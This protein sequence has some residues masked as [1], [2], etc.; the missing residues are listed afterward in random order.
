VCLQV[1]NGD[2]V[3]NF[4]VLGAQSVIHIHGIDCAT[5]TVYGMF[6]IFLIMVLVCAPRRD[7]FAELFHVKKVRSN[8]VNA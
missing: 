5:G 6:L 1:S 2:S 3:L 7:D 4:L 8:V